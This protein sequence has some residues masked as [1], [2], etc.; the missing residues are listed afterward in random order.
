[1]TYRDNARLLVALGVVS[2]LAGVGGISQRYGGSDSYLSAIVVG[3]PFLTLAGWF[4]LTGLRHR[5]VTNAHGVTV[6][7]TLRTSR[8]AWS[9]IEKIEPEAWD[10][11]FRDAPVAYL[12][13]G[14]KV[15]LPIRG[16]RTDVVAA[17]QAEL[18]AACGRE[19]SEEAPA[20]DE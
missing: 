3:L 4:I 15:R 1:M 13:D 18:K 16:A 19:A 9:E 10:W 5:I 11:T 6:T 2:L 17:L 7:K 12:R 8:I 20:S 14:S